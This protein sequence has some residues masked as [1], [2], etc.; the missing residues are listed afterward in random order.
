MRED[1]INKILD[2]KLIAIVRGMSEDK[3]LPL[4]EALY[5]GGIS[6]IEVTFN[7][8]DPSSFMA[9]TRSIEAIDRHFNGR[10]CAGAGTVI[11]EEQL[12][13]AHDAGA[14]YIISPHTDTALIKKTREMGLVSIPGVLTPTECIAAI[15]A[16][17]DFLKLFPASDLG[18][19]YLKAIRAPISHGR[20][21]CVGGITPA[22]IPE[23]IKAGAL[24]FG[25][26]G[27]LVNKE[28]IESGQFEKITAI[29]KE[30]VRA[31]GGKV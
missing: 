26:G 30:F 21:L 4:A 2:A 17:A 5:S 24:G 16:G 12:I 14:K 11:T 22:N 1:I 18:S 7:Q 19:S 15:N 23:F 31:V 9:T 27:N 8:K 10:V 13:L 3:I 20:Y 28:W 6:M 25:V 29:A